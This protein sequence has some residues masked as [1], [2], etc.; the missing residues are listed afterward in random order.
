MTDGVR[1][2]LLPNLLPPPLIAPSLSVSHYIV[3]ELSRLSVEVIA[4]QQ[5]PSIP[6][7]LLPS[8]HLFPSNLKTNEIRK[9]TGTGAGAT[10]EVYEQY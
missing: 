9:R 1:P 5:R 3:T 8:P 10:S 7:T 4:K 6:F 2:N